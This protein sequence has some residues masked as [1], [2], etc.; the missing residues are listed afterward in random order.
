MRQL[1]FN[2]YVLALT[3]FYS[4]YNNDA[5]LTAAIAGSFCTTESSYEDKTLKTAELCILFKPGGLFE[6]KAIITATST[7]TSIIGSLSIKFNIS[8]SGKYNIK[9]SYLVYES[10]PNSLKIEPEKSAS[11]LTEIINS[12]IQPFIKDH[13]IPAIKQAIIDEQTDSAKILE[14]DDRK[15]V[16]EII[17]G[18]KIV[19][20]RNTN[21]VLSSNNEPKNS[22]TPIENVGNSVLFIIQTGNEYNGSP[23]GLT[24]AVPFVMYIDGAYIEPPACEWGSTISSEIEK[25]TEAEKLLLPVVSPG[26]YLYVLNNGK[27]TNT[28]TIAGAADYGFSKRKIHSAVLDEKP[29]VAVI[30]NN[31]RLGTNNLSVIT[32]KPVLEKLTTD[33]GTILKEKL[34]T[35]VDIDGD[36]TPEL[37]YTYT[38][39]EIV[40]YTIYSF[41]NGTWNK[42]YEGGHQFIFYEG[43][44]G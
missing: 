42:V 32:E 31:P 23:S 41:K 22:G 19:Y 37:I 20:Q 26:N 14:L 21:T 5:K 11:G 3:T 24:V 2:F 43:S 34:L 1:L 33:D 7:Q 18:K 28:L 38:Y 16:L 8:L 4:C 36:G 10:N 6:K 9:D 29:G 25:C 27:Q 17:K 30:T 35:K 13:F 39:D 15:L 40:F 44:G 12:S